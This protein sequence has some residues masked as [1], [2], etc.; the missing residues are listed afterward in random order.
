MANQEQETWYL[1]N[2]C[3]LL[4]DGEILANPFT[5]NYEIHP[6]TIW[7]LENKKK[8]TRII[9]S[10]IYASQYSYLGV[11]VDDC[12][13]RILHYFIF[14]HPK[15]NFIPFVSGELDIAT[16]CVMHLK[17]L[18]RNYIREVK[19]QQQTHLPFLNSDETEKNHG[20]NLDAVASSPLHRITLFDKKEAELDDLFEYICEDF[21]E[22]FFNLRGYMQFDIELY[23]T[24]T[25]FE[26]EH[27]DIH[28]HLQKASERSHI[29]LD[30]LLLISAGLRE[31]LKNQVYEATQIFQALQELIGEN[32]LQG[33]KPIRLREVK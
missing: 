6:S 24:Y 22:Y 2:N 25:Y 28:Q 23:F 7:L 31:D 19:Q 18:T 29:P 12:Y 13:Q 20:I 10:I 8:V 33:W 17:N 3:V 15:Q 1:I 4:H 16:Y 14:E 5:L 9:K 27:L 11:N 26:V 21:T 30:L 32:K